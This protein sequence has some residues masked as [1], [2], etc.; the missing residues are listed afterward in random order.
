MADKLSVVEQVALML[1]KARTATPAEAEM[2]TA[3]AEKLLIRHGLTEAML[4][5]ASPKAKAEKIVTRYFHFDGV[6]S[7]ALSDAMA[8]V[9]EAFGTMR[10][11]KSGYKKRWSTVV[12]GHESDV[13]R[14][15]DLFRSL[16]AQAHV[17]Q[18]AWWK[19]EGK[20]N[21]AGYSNAEQW[22]ARRQF[23][24]SFGTG[25]ASRIK[26]STRQA[27]AET[28]GSALVLV[29]RKERVDEWI[30]ENM[31]VGRS[32]NRLGAAYGSGAGYH[33]G[34]NA[35]TGGSIG[36]GSRSAINR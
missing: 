34:R 14:L 8:R 1:E 36:G 26:E 29:G 32:R 27:T 11:M 7:E 23:Y 24:Y 35:A 30:D 25:V 5:A 6:F 10:G 33:A 18:K 20:Y 15:E 13:N 16:E 9:A 12:V 28:T 3:R 2:L 17:A 4:A 21:M 22:R 19:A 31:R